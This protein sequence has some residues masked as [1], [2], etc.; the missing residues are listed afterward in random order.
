MDKEEIIRIAER[1]ET[2]KT[3]ILPFED[4]CTLF[5]PEHPITHP[6]FERLTADFSEL[7][8]EEMMTEAADKSEKIF[9]NGGDK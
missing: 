6:D 8:I 9:L 1:I 4:C 5:A 2:Y 7:G 3:S